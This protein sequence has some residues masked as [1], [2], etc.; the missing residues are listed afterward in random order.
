MMSPRVKIWSEGFLKV[1]AAYVKDLN[2]PDEK[3]GY[4]FTLEKLAASKQH[5]TNLTNV[6]FVL[7]RLKRIPAITELPLEKKEEIWAETLRYCAKLR[8]LS[9]RKKFSYAIYALASMVDKK[10]G[11]NKFLA[12]L[13]R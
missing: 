9:E 3:S 1:G 5:R 13:K 10:A 11:G 4:A 7:V 8:T 6:Y 2:T 12:G